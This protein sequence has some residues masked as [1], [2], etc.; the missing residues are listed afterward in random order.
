MGI[1]SV[2]FLRVIRIKRN[3]LIRKDSDNNIIEMISDSYNYCC[4]IM[5]V[6]KI[7]ENFS[8]RKLYS[9]DRNMQRIYFAQHFI[10]QIFLIYLKS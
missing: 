6:K 9:K 1:R 4:E 5:Q 7:R 10:I 8:L 3:I 2:L